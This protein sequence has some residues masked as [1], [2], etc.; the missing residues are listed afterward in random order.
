M[1]SRGNWPPVPCIFLCRNLHSWIFL[2][3]RGDIVL[4]D[5]CR[6]SHRHYRVDYLSFHLLSWLLVINI[7]G[8]LKGMIIG[9]MSS[10]INEILRLYA[11]LPMN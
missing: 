5:L 7:W 2:I 8:D 11:H 10:L 6:F 9:G 3:F 1:N 4:S